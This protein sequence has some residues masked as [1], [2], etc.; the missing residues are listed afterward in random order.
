MAL[1]DSAW[2]LT[3]CNAEWRLKWPLDIELLVPPTVDIWHSAPDPGVLVVLG[4]Y[5]L[6]FIHMVRTNEIVDE[7]TK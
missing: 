2:P 6:S 7:C 4:D 3:L 1:T 5:Y